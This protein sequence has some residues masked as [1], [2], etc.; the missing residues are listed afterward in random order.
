M[1]VAR[2]KSSARSLFL[3][4]GT[5]R[6]DGVGDAGYLDHFG[7]VMHAD[8]VSALQDA[9]GDSCGGAPGAVVVF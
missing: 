1:P 6:E 7:Y 2:W 8:Y 4:E 3:C 9:G 5:R